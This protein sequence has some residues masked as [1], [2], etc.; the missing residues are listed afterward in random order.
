[1][2]LLSETSLKPNLMRTSGSKFDWSSRNNLGH[3]LGTAVSPKL[4]MKDTFADTQGTAAKNLL[5]TS[6]LVA[7]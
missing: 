3:A 4:T 5:F 6:V 1:M 2:D 7:S